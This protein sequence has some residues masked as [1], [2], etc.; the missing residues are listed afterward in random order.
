MSRQSGGKSYDASLAAQIAGN[1]HAAVNDPRNALD[2]LAG[3]PAFERMVTEQAPKL[4]E[5]LNDPAA[6][7]VAAKAEQARANTTGAPLSEAAR[8]ALGLGHVADTRGSGHGGERT[9]SAGYAR[10]LSG[11]SS[12]KELASEGYSAAQVSSAVSYAKSL[13]ISDSAYAGY[14]VGSSQAA[15]DA[16]AA[17]IKNGTAIT[18]DQVNKTGDVAAIIGAVKAGKMKAE[19]APPSVQKVLEKMKK[20]GVDPATS[21]AK[22]VRK[23]LK[24]HPKALEQAK[25]EIARHEKAD[26][27]LTREQKEAK[28]AGAEKAAV[29]SAPKTDTTKLAKKTSSTL[30]L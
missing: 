27:G 25:A 24:E 19:D 1:I 12:Y 2:A 16:I 23:Y 8:L 11:S 3:T 4:T 21:D 5:T 9:S 10:E 15:R 17:H 29:K 14:F 18:D 22:D 13:G 20:D 28:N 30:G 7:M 6:R 26:E